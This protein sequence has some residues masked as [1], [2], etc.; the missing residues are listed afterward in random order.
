MS[1]PKR[2]PSGAMVS[3]SDDSPDVTVTVGLAA[4]RAPDDPTSRARIRNGDP[5]VT[6]ASPGSTTI[7]SEPGSRCA[8]AAFTARLAG[9]HPTAPLAA[10]SATAP[11]ARHA[12]RRSVPGLTMRAGSSSRA[13]AAASASTSAPIGPST[14]ATS[15]ADAKRSSSSGHCS[16][17]NRAT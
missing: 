13:R 11:A 12:A 16:S 15:A 2:S 6:R 5:A 3:V 9:A 14:A 8:R 1:N 17:M 4:S 7:D 10:S